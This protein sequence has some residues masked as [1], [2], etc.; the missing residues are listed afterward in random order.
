MRTGALYGLFISIGILLGT[1]NTNAFWAF[2]VPTVLT[3]LAVITVVHGEKVRAEELR[4]AKARTMK[5]LRKQRAY[6]ED[7]FDVL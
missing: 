1:Y 6:A 4:D 7:R 2:C 3:F 5:M